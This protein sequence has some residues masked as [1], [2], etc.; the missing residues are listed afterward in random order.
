LNTSY[1]PGIAI[2][3]ATLLA[4]LVICV[5]YRAL[6]DRKPKAERAGK[7]LKSLGLT[8][9]AF[10]FEE[11]SG[12]AVR[13]A[14]FAGRVWIASAIFTRCPLSC[15]R[16]TSVMKS[17]QGKLEGTG[18]RLVSVSVDPDHDTPGVLSDYSRRFEAD[19]T[20]WWFLRGPKDTT[21]A[22]IRDGFLLP[23]Q[24]SSPGEVAAG[25]EA[26]GHSDRL[27]LL[28]GNM[29]LGVYD[30]NDP[31]ELADLVAEARRLDRGA[32]PG[33]ARLLPPV[34]ATLNGL[35]ALALA[36]GWFFIRSGNTRAHAT[37]MIAAVVLSG[38]FLTCYLVYHAQVGSK[39][40]LGVGPIRLVYF[41][42]LLS[43][44]VLATLGVVPLVA[45]TLFRA[46]RKQ[47]QRH[48]AIA[49][50]TFPIWMYVSVTG[51]IIYLMLYQLPVTSPPPPL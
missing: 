18:V 13:N 6:A 50:V 29:T 22:L 33:W 46:G 25:A 36:I 37:C 8:L 26:F 24:E 47:F 10:Q 11:R 3:L 20:R 1:R 21:Y 44:T 5:A 31:G 41:T 23:V 27:V 7:D 32:V 39:P 34:N 30:S 14:D 45:L 12:R 51:V 38:V 48:A 4:S 2:V 40:F 9:P 19:P 28:E 17:L 49:R 42:I 43:H 15:P 16:I 35:S